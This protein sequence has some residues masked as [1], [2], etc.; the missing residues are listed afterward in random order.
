MK[1]REMIASLAAL[2]F[3][4]QVLPGDAKNTTVNL[5]PKLESPNRSST[6]SLL[7]QITVDSPPRQQSRN[8]PPQP[9]APQ[10][11]IELWHGDITAAGAISHEDILVQSANPTGT[12][13]GNSAI[14][15]WVNT[16]LANPPKEWFSFDSCLNVSV[17]STNGSAP[18][19]DI[20]YWNPKFGQLTEN[21]AAPFKTD[22]IFKGA[23]AMW[24]HIPKSILIPLQVGN[25]GFCNS[26][27]MLQSLLHSALKLGGW[28]KYIPTKIK[29]VL[30]KNDP[31][32][33]NA[34]KTIAKNYDALRG[35]ANKTVGLAPPSF[36]T[37]NGVGYSYFMKRS[38]SWM[39]NLYPSVKGVNPVTEFQAFAI[40]IYT[41]GYFTAM[42][43]PL[44]MNPLK[45]DAIAPLK[46]TNPLPEYFGS[47]YSDLGDPD[48]QSLIPLYAVLSAGLSN[49]PAYHGTTFRGA[50]DLSWNPF[51]PGGYVR[52]IDYMSSAD[53]FYGEALPWPQTRFRDEAGNKVNQTTTLPPWNTNYHVRTQ[54]LSARDISPYSMHQY[55]RE[56]LYDREF[57]EYVTSHETGGLTPPKP[58][59]NTQPVTVNSNIATIQIPDSIGPLLK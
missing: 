43:N 57:I 53:E 30:D 52:V 29:I 36:P 40:N 33:V 59:P 22:D 7:S 39:K 11:V 16:L 25:N 28:R 19:R 21:Q 32:A 50:G 48:Y 8:V 41:S 35:G 14:K 3:L 56:H 24:G 4:K 55:E 49:I 54:S 5:S 45:T 37:S 6:L 15:S 10:P 2:P 12:L 42:Q 38:N 31:N 27:I 51:K 47:G 46:G 58:N 17:M 20:L 18:V 9:I 13:I 34:F 1:R 26:T 44:W 23:Q